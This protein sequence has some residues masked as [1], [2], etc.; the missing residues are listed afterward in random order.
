MVG[1]LSIGVHRKISVQH[2]IDAL[3]FVQ[4]QA[5]VIPDK[6]QLDNSQDSIQI[7]DVVARV[8]AI[9]RAFEAKG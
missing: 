2:M 1:L 8:R 4:N 7:T 9:H 6:V 5:G 3:N